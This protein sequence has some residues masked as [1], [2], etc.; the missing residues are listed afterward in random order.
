LLVKPAIGGTS[1]LRGGLT[2]S[3]PEIAGEVGHVR[4][5]DR[6]RHFLDPQGEVFEHDPCPGHACG[7]KESLESLAGL[8]FEMMLQTGG[9]EAHPRGEGGYRLRF[10]EFARDDLKYA[11]DPG[12]K[13]GQA[14]SSRRARRRWGES[15]ARCTANHR[16]DRLAIDMADDGE[17][18]GTK[19][20]AKLHPPQLFFQETII[21][22]ATYFCGLFRDKM[23]RSR[24][25][26]RCGRYWPGSNCAGFALS[27]CA[28]DD[29]QLQIRPP[30]A[31]GFAGYHAGKS[32][33]SRPRRWRSELFRIE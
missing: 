21:P 16:R 2:V 8:S 33:N 19:D 4:V 24:D 18:S 22:N 27:A 15:G 5:P 25:G 31:A 29:L 32:H 23:S 9:A 20:M 6:G 30:R 10:V 11:E 7:S 14:A 28:L 1:R 13:G 17:S 12:V 3:L 26:L